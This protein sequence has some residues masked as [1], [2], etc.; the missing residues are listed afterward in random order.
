MI[1]KAIALYA[2]WDAWRNREGWRRGWW[3]PKRV[4][5]VASS[6]GFYPGATIV[7]TRTDETLRVTSVDHG[8]IRLLWPR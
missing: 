7:N 6:H 8:V 2:L 1:G 3:P 4:V 5:R